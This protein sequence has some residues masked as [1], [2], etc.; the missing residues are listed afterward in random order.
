MTPF[1]FMLALFSNN[2]DI[3]CERVDE[4]C[5]LFLGVSW[6]RAPVQYSMCGL[7]SSFEWR[8]AHVLVSYRSVQYIT[9]HYFLS[10]CIFWMLPRRSVVKSPESYSR[11]SVVPQSY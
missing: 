3:D 1:G 10:Y 2:C 9:L 4:L 6:R 7:S 11:Y 8:V 5:Q